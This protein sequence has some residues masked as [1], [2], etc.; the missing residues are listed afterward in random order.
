MR[1]F[2]RRRPRRSSTASRRTDA[3]ASHI[4]FGCATATGP[5]PDN[6]DRCE[7][8]PRWVI[9]SDGAGGYAGGALAAELTVREVVACLDAS[10]GQID[11]TVV[12]HAVM[13]ANTAVRARRAS[14]DAVP[15]MVATLT[16]AVAT[17]VHAD[18]SSWFVVNVGDS[19][20]WLAASNRCTRVTEEH[21]MAAELVR[22]GVIS[23][24]AARMHPG[25]H[26]VTQ[27]I[28]AVDTVM[29]DSAYV[30]L[31]PGDQLVVASDGLEVLSEPEI[32]AV[33]RGAPTARDAARRLVDAALSGDA[34]DNVTVA[35][36]RHLQSC[37]DASTG[38]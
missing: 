35:V 16:L 9:I 23:R 31:H 20:A 6:Q 34:S 36:L 21:N 24:D 12:N 32:Q 19:P 13:R 29:V 14:D 2:G 7:V 22:S 30:A 26:V 18:E 4:D 15:D 38:R 37:G 33:I 27:A 10:E 17:A 8:S 25:R 5:R 3:V 28:G 11:E 1:L